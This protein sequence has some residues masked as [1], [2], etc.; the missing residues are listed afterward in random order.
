LE[1][2]SLLAR[3][4]ERVVNVPLMILPDK[5]S[6]ILSVIGER[7]GID[8][9][10][11]LIETGLKT[12]L[13]NSKSGDEP[14]PENISVIPVLGSLVHRTHGLDAMSGLTSYEDIRKNFRAAL[15]EKSDAILFDI[16]SPG[17]EAHGLMDLVDEIYEARGDKP[18]YAVA[19]EAAYSAAYAIASAADKIFLSRSAGVGSV[20][21]IAIHRD[22]SKFDESV[23][24][25]YTPVYAGARKND[26]S[27]HHP[28]STEARDFLKEEVE[29]HYQMFVDTVA[30]NRGIPVSKVKSTEAGLFTGDSA[31]AVGFA[32]EVRPFVS[33]IAGIA[34][35]ELGLSCEVAVPEIG[36]YTHNSKTKEGEPEWGSYI[37]KNRKS[38]PDLAFA[39]MKNRKY[40]HHWISGGQMYLHRGG[41]AAARSRAGQHDPG[42]GVKSHLDAHAKA[43]G[44]GETAKS[45]VGE[46]AATYNL[47]AAR[48]RA[49]EKEVKDKMP[50]TIA[51][52]KAE[53]PDLYQLVA[54]E[55]RQEVERDL[56]ASFDAEKTGLEDQVAGLKS[57]LQ[58]K[59]ESNQKLEAR[60]LKLEKNE[61]IRTEQEKQSRVNMAAERVWT[62]ALAVCDIPEHMHEK[63]RAMVKADAFVKEDVLD[64]DAFSKAVQEEIDEWEGKGMTTKVLGTGFSKSGGNIDPDAKSEE[65]MKAED[66]EW[67]KEMLA[68]GGQAEKGGD[69]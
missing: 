43:I 68:L 40:P 69:A 1:R 27:P 54:D 17:G 48:G 29:R 23:G 42:G 19:N 6:V 26:L 35:G 3:L 4:S 28:L 24:M 58:E 60:V 12:P 9:K 34:R 67:L 7:I 39:D 45:S 53:S 37:D 32:D 64:E 5:L 65:Q 47:H 30:R 59:D 56:R 8:E 36:A 51:E 10:I 55:I 25:K 21:V 14:I 16:N 20:G 15:E 22:Q 52:L 46:D 11:T 49:K 18:I 63:V 31:V 2:L 44:M 13:G 61:Y 62:R 38:L 50:N 41:L 33:T 66:D 57:Q